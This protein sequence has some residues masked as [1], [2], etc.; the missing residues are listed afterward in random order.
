MRPFYLEKN[1]IGNYVC[2][3]KASW[4]VFKFGK[5]YSNG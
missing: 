2:H 5:K 1:G 3:E 4:C